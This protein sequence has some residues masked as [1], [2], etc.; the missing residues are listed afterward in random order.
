MLQSA[1]IVQ[2]FA[3]QLCGGGEGSLEELVRMVNF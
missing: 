3:R 1:D 2:E